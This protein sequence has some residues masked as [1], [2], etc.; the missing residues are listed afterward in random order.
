MNTYVKRVI[1]SLLDRKKTIVGFAAYVLV[2]LPS[3]TFFSS[4]SKDNTDIRPE[5]VLLFYLGGD[6]DLSGEAYQKTEQ[7]LAGWNADP[8]CRLLIYS[9]PAGVPLPLAR[10]LVARERAGS[11]LCPYMRKRIQ[12]VAMSWLG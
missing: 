9:D 8:T 1:C 5:K 12:P 11:I 2:I 6:N 7:I 10:L 4:C 3:F